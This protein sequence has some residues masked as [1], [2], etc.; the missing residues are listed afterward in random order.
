MWGEYTTDEY[1]D[2][3]DL[4]LKITTPQSVGWITLRA[5]GYAPDSVESQNNYPTKCGVNYE[6]I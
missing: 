2:T 4:G 3:P 6:W 5:N 1:E